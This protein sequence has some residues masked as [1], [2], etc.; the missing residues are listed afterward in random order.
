MTR[1]VCGWTWAHM[2]LSARSWPAAG[3][4]HWDGCLPDLCPCLAFVGISV[5]N[6]PGCLRCSTG[7]SPFLSPTKTWRRPCRCMTRKYSGHWGRSSTG[8]AFCPWGRLWT[9]EGHKRCFSKAWCLL[10]TAFCGRVF[11][12]VSPARLNLGL[13][14]LPP[15]VLPVLSG[16]PS[17]STQHWCCSTSQ[18]SVP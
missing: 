13:L 17:H 18:L 2:Q 6:Q 9:W 16:S 4:R 11:R 1:P 14:C 10:V 8:P 5:S 15:Q 7:A 12:A 3:W